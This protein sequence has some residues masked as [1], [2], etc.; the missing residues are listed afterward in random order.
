MENSS[1]IKIQRLA[2]NEI[3]LLSST[4][5]HAYLD[6]FTYLWHD[7]GEWYIKHSFSPEILEKE[8]SDSN[9]RFFLAYID[10][11]P[12]GFLKLCINSSF[13]NESDID[14]MELER[15]YL[16]KSAMGK[17]IGK[18]FVHLAFDIAHHHHKKIIWLKA[19]GSSLDSISFYKKM[20]F[21]ICGDDKLNYPQ[22]KEEYRDMVVMKKN[23]TRVI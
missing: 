3:A 21:E 14:C 17:G 8:Y 11:Q 2:I 12:S 9:N 18:L 10:Q 22:M 15:I 6:H 19:M 5:I 4:A 13:N 20:G 23:L 16:R 7:N 1:Q